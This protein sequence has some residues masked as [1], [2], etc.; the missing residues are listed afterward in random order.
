[1]SDSVAQD[2]IRAFFERWQRAAA[3]L[4]ACS[5]GERDVVALMLRNEPVVVELMLAGR[6]LGACPADMQPGDLLMP[7]GMKIN[8]SKM[9]QG[10]PKP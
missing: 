8:P 4:A 10:Q 5:L 7:N 2:Q 6:W 9:P 3:A 1:M